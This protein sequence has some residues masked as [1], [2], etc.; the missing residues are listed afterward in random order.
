MEIHKQFLK[1]TGLEWYE[2]KDLY[3]EWLEEKK[4]ETWSIKFLGPCSALKHK[5]KHYK[6]IDFQIKLP[7]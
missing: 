1:D 7:S 4:Q 3:I 5:P 2:D 6:I